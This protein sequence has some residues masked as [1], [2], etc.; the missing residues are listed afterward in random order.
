MNSGRLEPSRETDRSQY[1]VITPRQTRL[2]RTPTLPAFQQAIRDAI[3]D[4]EPSQVRS[5]A[6]VVP[7]RAA[8]DQ[9][10]RTLTAGP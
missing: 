4:A 5:M 8:A 7:T 6:V 10:R 2:L 3:G 9:L 1:G